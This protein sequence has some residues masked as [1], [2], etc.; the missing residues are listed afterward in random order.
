MPQTITQRVSALEK[1]VARLLSAATH[2]AKARVKPRKAK[3]PKRTAKRAR[4][5]AAA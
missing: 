1:F 3:P 5:K 2:P 4:R